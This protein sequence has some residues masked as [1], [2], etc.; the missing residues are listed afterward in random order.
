MLCW[1]CGVIYITHIPVISHEAECGI[2]LFFSANV[3]A[4]GGVLTT[5]SCDVSYII[6]VL[7]SVSSLAS[8]QSWPAFSDHFGVYLCIKNLQVLAP[9]MAANWVMFNQ[10]W[11]IRVSTYECKRYIHASSFT[12]EECWTSFRISLL[13]LG[14]QPI[15]KRGLPTPKHDVVW[16]CRRLGPAPN[17]KPINPSHWLVRGSHRSIHVELFFLIILHCQPCFLPNLVA[18]APDQ[19]TNYIHLIAYRHHQKIYAHVW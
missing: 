7:Y 10:C 5:V 11:C 13:P 17:I 6:Q 12:A 15:E 8:R 16:F 2:S 3:C 19:L 9:Y 14:Y 4:L 18:I 1:L